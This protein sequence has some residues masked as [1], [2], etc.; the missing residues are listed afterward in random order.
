MTSHEEQRRALG[1]Y[2]VGALDPAERAEIEVHLSGCASC[3]EDLAGLAGLPGLLSRLS[4]DEALGTSLV[5]PPTLLPRVLDAVQDERRRT[6]TAVRRWRAATAGL[7]AV[8]VAA[9]LAGV[10]VLGPDRDA[11]PPPQLFVAAAGVGAEGSA[12]FEDRAWGT[13]V[14]LQVTG[15]PEDAGPFQAW[16]EDP[17]GRRTAVATW[18]ATPNGAADVT[19]ATAVTRQELSL[20]VVTTAD[21]EPLLRL[22]PEPAA[23]HSPSRRTPT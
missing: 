1:S 12:S 3:R 4:V 21:G 2:V 18:G 22:E 5:P 8:M 9:T 7:A 14:R 6:R 23:A 10:L 13:S 17:A 20:L 11:A 16:A 15:L 19:G